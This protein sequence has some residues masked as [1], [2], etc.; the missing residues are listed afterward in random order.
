MRHLLL[1]GPLFVGLSGLAQA[2]D[3][4][5]P[6]AGAGPMVAPTFNWAGTYVGV[7][8]GFGSGSLDWAYTPAPGTAN[9]STSGGLLGVTAG[10]N[11]LSGPLLYGLEGDVDLAN[12][13]GSTACP[14][15]AFSCDSN[16]NWLGTLRGRLGWTTNSILFYGTG[17]LAVGGVNISTTH[18]GFVVPPSGT[19]TNGSTS[20]DI[21]WTAGLGAEFGFA[22]DWS[23]K[24]EWLYYNLGSHLHTVDGNLKVNATEFGNIFKVGLNKH[25]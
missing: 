3:L 13:D 7:N 18:P 10:V 21:G 19:A 12:I 16:L 5:Y 24:A 23:V 20:T 2:A 4:T 14:N 8:G 11:V 9:H 17:G 15:A 1:A 25:F 22:N 6:M